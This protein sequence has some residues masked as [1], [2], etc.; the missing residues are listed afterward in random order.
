MVRRTAFVNK[1]R[2]LEYHYKSRQKRTDLYRKAGGTDFI[3]VPLTNLLEEE[4]IISTL[5]Q[6]GVP[7]A[8]IQSF[9]ISAKS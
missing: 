4:Y 3:F 5:R 8:K 9:L 2:T 1:I 7:E 6:K